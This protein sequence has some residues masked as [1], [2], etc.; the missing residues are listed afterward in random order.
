LPSSGSSARCDNQRRNGRPEFLSRPTRRPRPRCI[1]QSALWSATVG[2]SARVQESDVDGLKYRGSPVRSNCQKRRLDYPPKSAITQVSA[3]GGCGEEQALPACRFRFPGRRTARGWH[4]QIAGKHSPY[5]KRAEPWLVT[6][7][8][9]G[10]W[11][12]SFHHVGRVD[13]VLRIP[14]LRRRE[15]YET[16]PSIV[17]GNRVGVVRRRDGS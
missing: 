15:L 10:R 7:K 4:Y 14:S 5:P 8:S 13:C 6:H 17:L 1:P 2:C 3:G 12:H 9:I 16:H 11:S